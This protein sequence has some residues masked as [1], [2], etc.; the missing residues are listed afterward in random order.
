MNKSVYLRLMVSLLCLAWQTGGLYAQS[1]LIHDGV[2]YTLVDNHLE[3]TRLVNP[4]DHM[5]IPD[6][7]NGIRV[8]AIANRAFDASANSLC[9]QV[10][11]ITLGPHMETIGDE[12]F[13]L[14]A[15][16]KK[17]T[18]GQS[19]TSIGKRAF[20]SCVQLDGITFPETLTSLGNAC[21]QDCHALTS[22]VLPASVQLV[23][24]SAFYHCSS[25][26]TLTVQGSQVQM[27]DMAFAQTALQTVYFQGAPPTMAD[28][29]FR[30]TGSAS[31]PVSYYVLEEQFTNYI[32]L[33]TGAGTDYGW[34]TAGG[35]VRLRTTY[36]G[37]VY[38]Y[39]AADGSTAALLR[40][41]ALDE[42]SLISKGTSRR[43]AYLAQSVA[44]LHGIP[45]S[46][47]TADI[48]FTAHSLRE[49]IYAIDLR[50]MALTGVT[51]DRSSGAFNGVPAQTFIYVPEGNSSTADNVMVG[52]TRAGVIR[53]V[54]PSRIYVSEEI[55]NGRATWDLND[56]WGNDLFGQQ[57][58][59]D[60]A[61]MLLEDAALQKVWRAYFVGGSMHAYRFANPGK[62]VTLPGAAAMDLPE[63]TPMHFYIDD[64]IT[65]LFTAE[66]PLESDLTVYGQPVATSLSL[67]SSWLN[68][69]M[70]TSASQRK[71]VLVAV[72]T[73]ERAHQEV[74]W[75]SDNPEIARVDADGTVWAL[76]AGVTQITA[77]SV[78]NMSVQSRCGVTVLPR[79]QRVV[80][81]ESTITL[82]LTGEGEPSKAI[83]W[84][85]YPEDANQDVLFESQNPEIATVDDHG[86]VTGHKAGST[87]INVTP[88]ENTAITYFC[89]VNVMPLMEVGST[90][91]SNGVTYLVDQMDKET[92]TMKVTKIDAARLC[93]GNVVKVPKTIKYQNNTFTV[94]EVTDTAIAQPIENSFVYISSGV[95]YKGNADNVVCVREGQT[96]YTCTKAVLTEGF[97]FDAAYTFTAETLVCQRTCPAEGQ[98]FTIWLPFSV[99]STA[100]GIKF[101]DLQEQQGNE[102]IF[103]GI[104]A[105]EAYKPYLATAATTTVDLGGSHVQIPAMTRTMSVIL[106]EVQFQPVMRS[107]TVR[108]FSLSGSY[109]YLPE[110]TS[111]VAQEAETLLQPL[112]AWIYWSKEEPLVTKLVET[113]LTG[114][115]AIRTKDDSQQAIYDLNGRYLGTD[116]TLL[117]PGLYI[118]NGR[119]FIKKK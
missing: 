21:F 6:E 78:D 30:V 67:N 80:L 29:V 55:A 73:P 56:L 68:F 98:L 113:D 14:C 75:E 77:Y 25:L 81:A 23:D 92:K 85:V 7:I 74:I 70:S 27:S 103:Q 19:L 9:N 62:T 84:H 39:V 49:Q 94:T 110:G 24:I 57:I 12:A 50:Q 45:V 5:E 41:S 112:T 76:S 104:E 95:T 52:G 53:T 102:L 28:G 54:E 43:P 109:C 64:D 18:F 79:P 97:P 91:V 107:T 10:S 82:L 61:P 35:H 60:A 63:D 31:Q 65:R 42:A 13:Y 89:R 118:R 116:A 1:T 15:N 108:D 117:Q 4:R 59:V 3:A 37:L 40:V 17:I 100:D 115:A 93:N 111:W 38:D 26:Q 119:K 47:L 8:T 51:V 36:Q 105:T 96:D 66:T 44:I 34:T 90:M 71:A 99:R 58:G 33:T 22:V 72:I 88:V 46:Q 86:L 87:F 32:A 20:Y 83:E 114:M 16:L 106:D 69:R 11:Q 101:Y 48:T 2:E